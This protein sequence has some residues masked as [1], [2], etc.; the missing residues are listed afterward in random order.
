MDE[1][2]EL[3]SRIWRNFEALRI[4]ERIHAVPAD[5][6][7]SLLALL[8]EVVS[9]ACAARADA[10]PGLYRERKPDAHGRR[11]TAIQ[12]FDTHWRER[13]GKLGLYSDD[14][15]R[16][17]PALHNALCAHQSYRGLSIHDL[18]PASPTRGKIPE[19]RTAEERVA[20]KRKQQRAAHVR[21]QNRRT[22]IP[23]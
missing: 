14:L 15:K 17:D 21:Q 9:T 11:Q 4:P 16:A 8:D 2:T 22:M 7:S 6:L 19:I 10:V 23:G 12:F 1:R 3:I 13:A 18:L 5:K 20:H